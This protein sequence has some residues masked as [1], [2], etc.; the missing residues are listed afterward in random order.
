MTQIIC[1]GWEGSRR[2]VAEV[3]AAIEGFSPNSI[4]IIYSLA[5]DTDEAFAWLEE[6]YRRRESL[7]INVKGQPGF[8][9]IRSDPRFEDLVRRIGFPAD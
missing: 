1:C 8:D 2:A 7:M 6:G 9:P 3:Y 4:A 5:G